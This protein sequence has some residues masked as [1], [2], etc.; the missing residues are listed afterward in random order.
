[1]SFDKD[2]GLSDTQKITYI[3][4]ENKYKAK[5]IMTQVYSAL[6]DKEYDPIMQLVGYILSGDPTYIP[7]HNN[8]R[9]LIGRLERDELLE[10][11]INFY[12]ENIDERQ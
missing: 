11:I 9:N 6:L 8:A 7:R 3:G 10:E 5:E 1:M 2:R 4:K 12:L